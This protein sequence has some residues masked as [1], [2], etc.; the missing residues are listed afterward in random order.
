MET[1][2]TTKERVLEVYVDAYCT[3]HLE[4]HYVWQNTPPEPTLIGAGY[5]EQQAWLNAAN[6]IDNEK[7]HNQ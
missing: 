2:K 4:I 6:T 5:T 3:K 7:T 1:S